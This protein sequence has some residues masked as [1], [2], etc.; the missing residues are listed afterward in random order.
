MLQIFRNSYEDLN[1]TLAKNR[2]ITDKVKHK[3]NRKR[4]VKQV[5]IFCASV[6]LGEGSSD[7]LEFDQLVIAAGADSGKEN[8]FKYLIFHKIQIHEAPLF[9]YH[10][11]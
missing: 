4:N 2:D 1:V 10:E 11:I 5:K 8:H 9:K 7:S 6:K 3:K